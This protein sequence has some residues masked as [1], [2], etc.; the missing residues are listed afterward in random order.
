MDHWQRTLIPNGFEWTSHETGTTVSLQVREGR[1]MALMAIVLASGEREK[2]K[3][4]VEDG[5]DASLQKCLLYLWRALN[6]TDKSTFDLHEALADL[7][8]FVP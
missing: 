8:R 6:M 3:F 7:R 4:F 1:W 5:Y 2:T